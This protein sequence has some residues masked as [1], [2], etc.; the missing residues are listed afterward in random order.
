MDRPAREG[1]PKCKQNRYQPDPNRYVLFPRPDVWPQYYFIQLITIFFF[2]FNIMSLPARYII[3]DIRTPDYLK[4]KSF[5]GYSTKDV[6]ATLKKTLLKN[7]I[8]ESCNWC[9]ELFLSLQIDKLYYILL[10]ISLRNMNIGCPQLPSRLLK[11]FSQFLGMKLSLDEMRNSQMIRN[12]IIELCAIICMGNKTKTIGLTTLKAEEME[13]KFILQKIQADR[14][15]IDG[16]FRSNDP[17]ELKFIINEI[18]YNMKT[19]NYGGCVYMLSWL[20]QYDKLSIKK[21]RHIV[22]HERFSSD[23]KKEQHTD[24]IWLLWEIIVS[25]SQKTLPHKAQKQID[26]LLR[27]YKLLY[28]PGSK[29]RYIHLYLFA[30]K[31]FTDIYDINTPI[32]YN[33]YIS[34]QLCMK[35]NH[36]IGQK[37]HLEVVK[38]VGVSFEPVKKK[39]EKNKT[40]K[41]I[42]EETTLNKFNI[43][44]GIDINNKTIL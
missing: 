35:I 6:V 38:N 23:I 18:V 28:K 5:S 7:N 4:E 3:N 9:I 19:K 10:D 44:S 34:L 22:C 26:N 37:K 41:Q 11:R 8:E 27:L 25:E 39:K 29:Y 15:Y 1:V 20:V 32:L 21:K 14:S 42:L 31:Y 12:H 24:I 2:L 36:M 43:L 13:A 16:I 30:L 33:K 40:K 17:D